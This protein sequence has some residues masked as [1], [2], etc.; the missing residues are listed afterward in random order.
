VRPEPSVFPGT[1]DSEVLD[2]SPGLSTRDPQASYRP[3]AT[4]AACR[5]AAAPAPPRLIERGKFGLVW[6]SVL[7]D[8]FL[9]G[10]PSH[11]L[12]HDLRSRATMSLGT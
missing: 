11:R 12:L 7:L 4:V 2:R 1:E 9:Y 8:K 5:H 10:R 3:P 6:A